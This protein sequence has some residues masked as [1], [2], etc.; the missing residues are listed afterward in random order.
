MKILLVNINIGL[1][2]GVERY[3]ID[4]RE[5]LLDK[6]IKVDFLHG[7][8]NFQ[9]RIANS[10]QHFYLPEIWL[11][12]N[13]IQEM[14]RSRLNTILN[15]SRPDIIYMHNIDNGYAIRFMTSYAP[16]VRYVHGFKTTCPDGKRM[17]L[18]PKSACSYPVGLGCLFRAHTRLC[19]PRLPLKAWRAYRRATVS[20]AATR[21]LPRLV[22]ASDF[23]KKLLVQNHISPDNVDVLPSFTQWDGESYTKPERPHGLLFI[24][25]LA[26]GKGIVELIE[27]MEKIGSHVQ[28]DIV[29]DGPLRKK[30]E[31]KS[32]RLGLEKRITFY[33]WMEEEALKKRYRSNAL[34]VVPSLWPEPF[35]IIGLEAAMVCRPVV[36]FNTGGVS[37]WLKDGETGLLVKAGDFRHLRITIEQFL[38]KCDEMRKMGITAKEFVENHFSSKNHIEKLIKLFDKVARRDSR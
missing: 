1:V 3:L 26:E 19:M 27:L 6:R 28:L 7:Q 9:K 38:N 35:G 8:K 10:E 18:R 21:Q 37:D 25:R 5:M 36:A 15:E 4:L 17:L 33:G 13:S 20:L 16:V 22:V 34:I 14:T 2:G 12:E 23:M 32:K 31:E 29:G 24:G 30:A 11:D